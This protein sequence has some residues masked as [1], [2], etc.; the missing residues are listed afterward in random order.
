[1]TAC[2]SRQPHEAFAFSVPLPGMLASLVATEVGES[3]EV[4]VKQDWQCW[5]LVAAVGL[6]YTS[7]LVFVSISNFPREKLNRIWSF[8]STLL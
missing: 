1:M 6:D 3:L 4:W 7:L 2:S 5:S 8:L